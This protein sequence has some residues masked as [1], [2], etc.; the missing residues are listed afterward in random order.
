MV[1]KWAKKNSISDD[2]LLKTLDDLSR[3]FGTLNLGG[4]LYKIRIKRIGSGKSSG[5]RT[6]VVFKE[7]DKAIYIY[8]FSKTERENLEKDELKSFKKLAKIYYR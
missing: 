8:G 1:L 4:G 7:L 3:N 5:Y 6:L 2:M